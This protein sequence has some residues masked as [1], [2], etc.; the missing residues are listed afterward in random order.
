MDPL[1]QVFSLLDVRSARCTRFEASGSW[2]FHLP[3][4]A[5]IRFGSVIRGECWIDFGDGQRHQLSTGDSFLFAN[6]PGYVIGNDV[7]ASP[8]DGMAMFDWE[9]S[10]VGRYLGDETVLVAGNFSFASSDAELLLD[11]L[12]CFLRIPG[13]HPSAAVIRNTLQ[14]VIPEIRGSQIGA[15][16]MTDRLVDVLLILV[17]RAALE[18]DRDN[19]FGWIGALTDPRI[20][21][22]LG[23]MHGNAA[24]PWNLEM[25]CS[26]VA[27]SRSAFCK[28]FSLLVGFAPLDYLLRWR[29]RLA[30]DQLRRGATV[31]AAAVHVGYVSESGFRHAFKRV[32]GESPKRDWEK[33]RTHS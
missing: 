32:Y 30:R 31:A 17:L 26:A 33:T 27:M 8:G 6:A 28:R 2:S 12:P 15:G 7:T 10:D 1:S 3:A 25:L 16:I 11:A 20:G 4:A 18:Q 5:A 21:K 13:Q 9:H 14:L 23:L 22:A 29:M 24:H 19:D